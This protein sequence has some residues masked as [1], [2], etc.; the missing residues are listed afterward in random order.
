MKVL[1]E[2]FKIVVLKVSFK[3]FFL[4]TRCEQK[5]TAR[6]AFFL[7]IEYQKVVLRSFVVSS[8]DLRKKKSNAGQAQNIFLRQENCRK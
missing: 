2:A 8:L 1:V 7:L 3:N 6:D 5:G 4:D